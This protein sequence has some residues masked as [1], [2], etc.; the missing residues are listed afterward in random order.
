MQAEQ[1]IRKGVQNKRSGNYAEARRLYLA[2]IEI[3][4]SYLH[5]YFAL[6][7]ISYLLADQKNAL[8]Y[9]TIAAHLHI[10]TG[11]SQDYDDD[12]R[13]TKQ[14][15]LNGFSD[16]TVKRFRS[17]HRYADLLL[18]DN[19]TPRHLGHALIDLS[20]TEH[21][22][23]EINRAKTACMQTISIGRIVSMDHEM[24]FAVYQNA[25]M[26][27][28]LENILGQKVGKHPAQDVFLLYAE[29]SASSFPQ[30]VSDTELVWVF[31]QLAERINLRVPETKFPFADLYKEIETVWKSAGSSRIH[32]TQS[33]VHEASQN[34]EELLS[35]S[36]QMSKGALMIDALDF[37]EASYVSTVN[38]WRRVVGRLQ[39]PLSDFIFA[40]WDV[41]YASQTPTPVLKALIWCL[42]SQDIIDLRNGL[43]HCRCK[44]AGVDGSLCLEMTDKKNSKVISRLNVVECEA[45]HGLVYLSALALEQ[46]FKG[47]NAFTVHN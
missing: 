25:G 33:L 46:Y 43:V 42:K 10:A 13:V 14:Q 31:N 38:R 20:S 47:V 21:I 7:K 12:T 16:A 23:P 1:L 4:P 35:D 17:V 6:G 39:S 9:Y 29:S 45:F 34:V 27:Y 30:V 37:G 3:E 8:L 5:C 44:L 19:N 28:L 40:T 24:E 36:T 26:S 2:A 41:A 22:T 32:D 11:V 15:I 18:C